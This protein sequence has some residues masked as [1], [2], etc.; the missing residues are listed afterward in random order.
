MIMI[1]VLC[2]VSRAVC[3]E[4]QLTALTKKEKEE[5]DKAGYEHWTS[6]ELDTI[7]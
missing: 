7:T 4:P 3:L 5:K 6:T 2:A 1:L